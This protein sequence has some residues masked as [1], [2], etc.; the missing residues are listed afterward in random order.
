VYKR[1]LQRQIEQVSR[2][3]GSLAEQ[4]E[5]IIS[6]ERLTQLR[7]TQRHS[8]SQA[9]Q[10]LDQEAETLA[11]R[12]DRLSAQQDLEARRLRDDWE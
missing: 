9:H 7:Q 8:L 1:Q 3:D 10:E 2:Q 4:E 11:R 5:Q 12:K 6:L